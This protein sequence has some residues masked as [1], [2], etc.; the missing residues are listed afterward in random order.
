M[1]HGHNT[2]NNLLLLL[3]ASNMPGLAHANYA[4][5]EA[6]GSAW[7]R[8]QHLCQMPGFDIAGLGNTPNM[9]LLLQGLHLALRC[10]RWSFW[11]PAAWGGKMVSCETVA[12]A[13]PWQNNQRA[14]AIAGAGSTPGLTPLMHII[15]GRQ[16][17]GLSTPADI[18]LSAA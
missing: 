5:R 13:L 10:S 7:G 3:G 8:E 18:C 2:R 17:L 9:L 15:L 6:A 14:T 16:Q 4:S 12:L 1:Q 11:S